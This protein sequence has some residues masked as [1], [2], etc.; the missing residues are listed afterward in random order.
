MG[1]SKDR[2][3]NELKVWLQYL[4]LSLLAIVFAYLLMAIKQ[5]KA[6][7]DDMHFDSLMR[8]MWAGYLLPW[9][10]IFIILSA[11]RFLVLFLFSRPKKNNGVT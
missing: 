6:S 5:S 10:I 8:I 11:L 7:E 4:T 9:L 3:K 2:L 1:I